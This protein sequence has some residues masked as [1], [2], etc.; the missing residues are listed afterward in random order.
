MRVGDFVRV[1]EIAPQHRDLSRNQVVEL[2]LEG[3]R[4]RL[5]HFN[6]F[7]PVSDL[8]LIE[9]TELERSTC[10]RYGLPVTN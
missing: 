8:E 4:A 10:D 5:R 2:N 7:L 6:H 3:D 1:I 9:P